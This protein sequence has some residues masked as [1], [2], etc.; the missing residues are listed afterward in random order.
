[1][2]SALLTRL[3]GK[4]SDGEVGVFDLRLLSRSKSM[5]CIPSL[6]SGV[7]GFENSSPAGSLGLGFSL[8]KKS[9]GF[10]GCMSANV[11]DVGVAGISSRNA[12]TNFGGRSTSGG[13]G[14][15]PSGRG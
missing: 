11:F 10:D 6:C 2:G 4:S 7:P 13:M 15:T 1:M 5:F 12:R 9:D 8:I 14:T 3:L